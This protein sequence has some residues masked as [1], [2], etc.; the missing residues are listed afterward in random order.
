MITPGNYF[1]LRGKKQKRL[2]IPASVKIV[3]VNLFLLGP[4]VA[5][6]LALLFRITLGTD[7]IFDVVIASLQMSIWGQIVIAVFVVALPVLSVYVNKR[8][9]I[10]TREG[11]AVVGI[12][13]AGV[14][15]LGG[16][17]IA[18]RPYLSF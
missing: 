5:F 11:I 3:F 4:A 14:L 12:L 6:W 18:V 1:E 10:K 16:V 2:K 7:Y 15:S 8:L 17:G 9:N 13:F